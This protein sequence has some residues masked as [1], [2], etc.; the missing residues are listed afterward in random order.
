MPNIQ[1]VE[2]VDAVKEAVARLDLDSAGAVAA[3]FRERGV[4]GVRARSQR[5][6]IAEYI[7]QETGLQ[8]IAATFGAVI[9]ST[10]K[11][12]CVCGA[13]GCMVGK[14]GETVPL[15]QAARD[16]MEVFDNGSYPDLV[17]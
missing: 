14:T 12:P 6:P 2:A 5:C 4:K 1:V 15:P 7:K 13:E 17:G 9:V 3:F 11:T 10:S 8:E 16:F